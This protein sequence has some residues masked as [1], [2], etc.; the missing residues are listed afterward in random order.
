ILSL[1]ATST[2]ACRQGPAADD[3]K[4]ALQS[5]LDKRFGKALFAITALSRKG[6][7]PLAAHD[8]DER[9][10]V[11]YDATLRFSR[12]HK[13]SAW[14]QLNVGSL[15]SV[16]GTTPL[17]VR[18]VK[19]KGNARGDDLTVHGA[20]AWARGGHGKKAKK[21]QS[22]S[23]R[24]IPFLPG[25]AQKRR[26]PGGDPLPYRKRLDRIAT[27]GKQLSKARKDKALASLTHDLDGLVS[28]SER[29]LGQALGWLTLATGRLG[30]EYDRQGRGLVRL[31]EAAGQK[32]RAYRSAGSRDNL[33]LVARSEV[34]FAYAQNDVAALARAGRGVFEGSPQPHLRALCS[35]YP[36][37]LQIVTLAHQV[38]LTVATL[39]G[40][41]VDIGP[42]GSGIRIN[43]LAVLKAAGLEAKDFATLRGRGLPG[44]LEDLAKGRVDAVFLTSAFPNVALAHLATTKKLDVL[45]LPDDLRQRLHALQPH[46][47]PMTIPEKTY[48]GISGPRQTVGV[49]ALLVARDDAP[50][51][52]VQALLQTLFA[53]VTALSRDSIQAYFISKKTARRG[54]SLPLHPAAA[55]FFG[56]AAPATSAPSAPSAPASA[57]AAPS[58]S[59]PTTP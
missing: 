54:V 30:G 23:W 49:T 35:L 58:A 24:P 44:S 34:L 8:G 10:L 43:A 14:N 40:K 38:P 18:G 41:R 42:P 13:F 5:R 22:T 53:N 26:G 51:K 16:L 1:L 47:L 55:R 2:V 31:L 6:H 48:E 4:Q 12:A 56:V 7:Y 21:N 11:Y 37:A 50:G 57:P 28:Q 32:A 20:L 29:R 15:I 33:Q 46:L 17:G 9:V 39:R 25:K 45:S 36:E 3:L 59:A 27:I 52:K 19:P